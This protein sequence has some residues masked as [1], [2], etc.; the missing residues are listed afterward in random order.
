MSL[1]TIIGLL[2][3]GLCCVIDLEVYLK[4]WVP[5]IFATYPV[6]DYLA[7][8]PSSFSYP[9]NDVVSGLNETNLCDFVK[10]ILQFYA[11]FQLSYFG[12]TLLYS[13]VAKLSSL[14]SW[15]SALSTT[16]A[17]FVKSAPPSSSSSEDSASSSADSSRRSAR[18]VKAKVD[19]DALATASP[20]EQDATV[21]SSV[22]VSFLEESLASFKSELLLRKVPTALCCLALG[23][24]FFWLAANSLHLNRGPGDNL[25]HLSA[26]LP[27]VGGFA[28][29]IH[30]LVAMEIALIPLLFLMLLDVLDS[31]RSR[32][33]MSDLLS[34]IE[35][36]GNGDNSAMHKLGSD[37]PDK[38][39]FDLVAAA[40][41]LATC[42]GS[43][44]IYAAGERAFKDAFGAVGQQHNIA[45]Y[46]WNCNREPEKEDMVGRVDG[47][48]DNINQGLA[49]MINDKRR[50]IIVRE[51]APILIGGIERSQWEVAKA[52]II[53][54]LNALAFYGYLL[55]VLIYHDSKGN[56]HPSA[57]SLLGVL[58]LG[59]DPK[60]V[61]WWG[62]FVGDACWTLEPFV[63]LFWGAAVNAATDFAGSRKSGEKRTT[64]KNAEEGKKAS[65]R[66]LSATPKKTKKE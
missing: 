8:T 59:L 37:K 62:N 15:D 65:G 58:Q 42:D 20:R 25:E 13:S 61:D 32:K 18:K 24:S 26:P 12:I 22:S 38:V 29:V 31:L 28:N 45:F 21:F 33:D 47:C 54:V 34:R 35:D 9:W 27:Y 23:V 57:S 64:R 4:P 2:R 46:P 17:K 52:A 3:N 63:L 1:P 41:D 5:F 6:R 49:A 43:S 19:R 14:S 60:L 36:D 53:L 11:F 55:G 66:G 51:A 10:A 44:D 40:A 39:A 56:L 16:K 7:L 48:V 50:P 30:S